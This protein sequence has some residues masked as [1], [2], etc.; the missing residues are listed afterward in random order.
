M[1]ICGY[2]DVWI[3]FCDM[4][5][6]LLYNIFNFWEIEFLFGIPYW[7]NTNAVWQKLVYRFMETEILTNRNF[8]VS[9][10]YSK[11]E[12]NFSIAKSV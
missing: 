4:L 1:K 10:Q 12:F 6:K 2:I 3:D 9:I 5:L 8:I 7:H 11:Y